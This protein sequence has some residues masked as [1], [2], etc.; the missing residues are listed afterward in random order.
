MKNKK[1][2]DDSLN[3]VFD[4]ASPK[5]RIGQIK[6]IVLRDIGGHE[7]LDVSMSPGINLI[8]GGNGSGKSSLVSGIA[9]LCG[10]NGRKA[11]KDTSLAKYIRIGASK[12]VIR[13]HFANNVNVPQVGYLP[14]LFGDEIIVER[15]IYLKGSSTYTFQGS[16]IAS[17]SY[18]SREAKKH[19]L[20]F[21]EFSN[22]IINNPITL[23]T[24]SDSKYL[25][26]EQSSPKSL[27]E[28]FQRAHLFDLSWKYLSEEQSHLE[29]AELTSQSIRYKIDKFEEE[30]NCFERIMGILNEYEMLEIHEDNLNNIY[31]LA[32]IEKLIQ[33][34]YNLKSLKAD[35][36]SE[37][38]KVNLDK[39][40]LELSNI[41]CELKKI[42]SE[43]AILRG[44]QERISKKLDGLLKEFAKI[45]DKIVFY[46]AKNDEMNGQIKKAKE[47][48]LAKRKS[49]EPTV[50]EGHPENVLS[51]FSTTKASLKV[52]LDSIIEEKRSLLTDISQI[53][54]NI[55]SRKELLCRN[56]RKHEEMV[57]EKEEND[58]RISELIAEVDK[59]SS[60]L[61]NISEKIENLN[62][63]LKIVSKNADS[64]S[65]DSELNRVPENHTLLSNYYNTVYD[66][67]PELDFIEI[68]GYSRTVHNR[69]IIEYESTNRGALIAGPIALHIFADK[70]SCGNDN[71]L[72]KLDEIIGG[73]VERP[74]YGG[75]YVIRR[76]YKYWI[77][78]SSRDKNLLLESFRKN[79]VQIDPTLIFIRS[80]F[81]Q[82]KYDLSIIR[83]RYPKVGL[84][85]IDLIEINNDEVFNFLVDIAQIEATFI[86]YNDLDMELIYD[87]NIYIKRAYSMESNSYRYRR[88]GIVVAPEVYNSKPKLHSTILRVLESSLDLLISN[89]SS[90]SN[91][92]KINTM[93][94]KRD[95]YLEQVMIFKNILK[96]NNEKIV[97][98]T[99]RNKNINSKIISLE[100]C[101][102]GIENEIHNLNIELSNL[103]QIL[104]KLS[105]EEHSV[106]IEI[107]QVKI[108][109][110]KFDRERF[111]DKN[112]ISL[113]IKNI[114]NQIEQWSNSVIEYNRKIISETENRAGKDNEIKETRF[115]LDSCN[116]RLSKFDDEI[117]S[118]M[119]KKNILICE[120]PLLKEKETKIVSEINNIDLQIDEIKKELKTIKS[121]NN[122][123]LLGGCGGSELKS[124]LEYFGWVQEANIGEGK[125]PDI[126]LIDSW[127]DKVNRQK[128]S[129]RIDYFKCTSI[130]ANRLLS[131]MSCLSSLKS[132]ISSKYEK[133][134]M[135]FENSKHE[136]NDEI[137]LLEANKKILDKRI[138]QLQQNHIQ[139]GKI[140]NANFKHYFS[141]FWSNTMKPHLKF[142]HDKSTLN[143]HVIPDTAIGKKGNADAQ[144]LN[145]G[146]YRYLMNREIQSLSGGE[147][148]S[149]GI[150]LL[151]ALSQ[152]NP[153]PFHIFDEPDVYMDDVRRMIMIQSFAEFQRLCSVE[154]SG[155]E[156]QVIFITPHNEITQFVKENYPEDIHI[157][158]LIKN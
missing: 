115:L 5:W 83:K 23:L 36:Y 64:T 126:K 156:R 121:N 21:R 63:T 124:T 79:G 76:N 73:K 155:N 37:K 99:M 27:Y 136:F 39:L 25:I 10:W 95:K 82:K 9:L 135:E 28:F 127:R 60:S 74:N 69:V 97:N 32:S 40:N 75:K 17:P 72:C 142:D 11:G 92:K 111:Q 140:V 38:S 100:S 93:S 35:L 154:K 132:E 86:F 49:F 53:K 51:K 81:Q 65:G 78:G 80:Q 71:L 30:I 34:I 152:S 24:Q 20:H 16:K 98:L 122:A 90:E 77:V 123:N 50:D 45:S 114:E 13:V 143:I 125:Y 101:S 144:C 1:T 120:I 108:E 7:F 68:F 119:N 8:T 6:R 29:K 22:I 4:G 66:N 102:E 59:D 88:G 18:N 104:N 103:E 31:T 148:S 33:S 57:R 48:I 41:E 106:S 70:S 46:T 149:I 67:Y 116:K 151:L 139:S 26:R 55:L 85:A 141:L 47:I 137:K 14:D 94:I 105:K 129:L 134:K 87:Y 147:S 19:L 3:K 133:K 54:M 58:S 12:G 89:N 84:A 110:E 52:K 96:V 158:Q 138:E 44:D 150:S 2:K 146:V 130:S 117:K 112:K 15:I 128:N 43:L 157:I 107:D 109:T 145:S 91:L 118:L 62:S 153:S 56:K 61:D 131:D 113:E 42:N